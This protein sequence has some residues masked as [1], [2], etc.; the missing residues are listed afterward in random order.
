[1]PSGLVTVPRCDWRE[2]SVEG[3]YWKVHTERDRDREFTGSNECRPRRGG[4]TGRPCFDVTYCNTYRFIFDSERSSI[5]RVSTLFIAIAGH[6][7]DGTRDL[8]YGKEVS[9]SPPVL[10]G[11]PKGIAEHIG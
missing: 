1:M 9:E 5:G 11:F 6:L 10:P 8:S 2:K 4:G 7:N 3:L